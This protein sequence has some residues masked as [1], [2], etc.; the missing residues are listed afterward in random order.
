VIRLSHGIVTAEYKRHLENCCE[1]IYND[2]SIQRK[3]SGIYESAKNIY[4]KLKA[5]RDDN[6]SFLL[7][8]PW[9]ISID[10]DDNLLNR[11]ALLLL[12]GR[13]TVKNSRFGSYSLSLTIVI[14]REASSTSAGR[15]QDGKLRSC[16]DL[17]HDNTT[18]DRTVR[19]FHFDIGTERGRET[20]PLCHLQYG[21][22]PREWESYNFHYCLDPWLKKPRFPFPP[23]DIV[24]LFDFLLKQFGTSFGQKF[25]EEPYWRNL[26]KKS[27]RLVLKNYYD[28]ISEYFRGDSKHILYE[29]LCCSLE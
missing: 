24:L 5:A 12:G 27:E 3:C 20:K 25:V 14:N 13:I 26:V 11:S 6:W 16:C 22:M 28:Q 1:A 9:I 7:D 21:G 10:N 8:P 18:Y 2:A 29:K 4:S 19:R 15:N 23:T 17:V